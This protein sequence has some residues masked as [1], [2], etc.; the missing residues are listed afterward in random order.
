MGPIKHL[1]SNILLVVFL[2]AVY[3]RDVPLIVVAEVKENK[4]NCISTVQAST[5]F[6]SVK[7]IGQRNHTAWPKIK[8]LGWTLCEMVGP[9]T[10]TWQNKW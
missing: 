1:F 9:F 6:A 5:S 10:V 8:G 4:P 2:P 3:L 7:S